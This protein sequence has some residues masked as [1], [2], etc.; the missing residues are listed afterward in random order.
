MGESRVLIAKT[1]VKH[2]HA[3]AHT[4]DIGVYFEANGHGTVL[5]GPKVGQVL[6]QSSTATRSSPA[7]QRLRLLPCLIHPA[8]GDA[9]SDL[10]LVDFILACQQWDLSKWNDNLYTDLPS[11]QLKVQVQ[12]RKYMECIQWDKYI[13][14][15]VSRPYE[16]KYNTNGSMI[17]FGYILTPLFSFCC[18]YRID[19]YSQSQ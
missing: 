11:R 7:W 9:L 18:F 5:F 14:M 12:D 13:Q 3:A 17:P 8:V 6:S 1:G 2:V 16:T 19:D 15:D 4:F 10:L